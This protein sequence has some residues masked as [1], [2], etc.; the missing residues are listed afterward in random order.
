MSVKVTRVELFDQGISFGE[1]VEKWLFRTPNTNNILGRGYYNFH[2]WIFHVEWTLFVHYA[3]IVDSFCP[4]VKI[5]QFSLKEWVFGTYDI[6][7]IGERLRKSLKGI[8]EAIKAFAKNNNS[9][10]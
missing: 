4:F 10:D 8:S 2:D 7:G 1:Y 5:L 3:K 6:L 9:I